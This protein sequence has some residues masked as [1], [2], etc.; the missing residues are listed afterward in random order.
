MEAHFQVA[1]LAEIAITAGNDAERLVK[2]ARYGSFRR[3]HDFASPFRRASRKPTEVSLLRKRKW[4]PVWS[5]CSVHRCAFDRRLPRLR[6]LSISVRTS[7]AAILITGTPRC[8]SS[9]VLLAPWQSPKRGRPGRE[10]GTR[11]LL[12][13]SLPYVV[14][15]RVREESIE[16]LRIYNSAQVRS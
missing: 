15:Y 5:K 4:T 2:D 12:F 6:T 8:A 7:K 13:P 9:S 1:R 14:V 16:V 10:A 11:E 3:M